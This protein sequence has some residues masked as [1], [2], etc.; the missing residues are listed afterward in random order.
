MQFLIALIGAN[1]FILFAPWLLLAAAFWGTADE[2]EIMR[3]AF[4]VAFPFTVCF[5]YM[6]L[7]CFTAACRGFIQGYRR[8]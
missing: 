5:W 3:Y 4:W 6:G 2:Q 7:H 1:L 8:G